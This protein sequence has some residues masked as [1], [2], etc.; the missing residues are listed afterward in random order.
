MVM[1]QR[2]EY[3]VE[4]KAIEIFLINLIIT[5]RQDASIGFGAPVRENLR[6]AGVASA[7]VTSALLETV[8]MHSLFHCKDHIL[9]PNTQNP[10]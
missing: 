3:I 2:S 6:S 1:F 10:C 8:R 9:F 7:V 4:K 5:R